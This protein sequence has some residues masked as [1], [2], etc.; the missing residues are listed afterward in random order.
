MGKEKISKENICSGFV[1]TLLALIVLWK[2]CDHYYIT[3][4]SLNV[5]K[6]N[7]LKRWDPG[8]ADCFFIL[9]NWDL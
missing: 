9:L 7:H 4:N 5:T 3:Q 2:I 1:S 8:F 6:A